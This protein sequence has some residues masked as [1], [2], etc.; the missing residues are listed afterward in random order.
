[1]PSNYTRKTVKA[2]WSSE[3]ME[4]A[5]NAIHNG[6]STREVSRTFGIARS[7]LQDR[8]KHGNNASG[9]SMGRRPVFTKDEKLLTNQVIKLSKLFYGISPTEIKR[10][11]FDYAREN[12][13]NNPFS[14]DSQ[15]AGKAWLRGFLKRNPTISLRKPEATSINRITAFNNDEVSR[16]YENLTTVMDKYQFPPTKI[17]NADETG[18]TTV[19]KPVK[20]YAEKGQRRVGFITSAKRGKTTTIM[21]AISASGIYVPPLFIYARKRMNIQLKRTIAAQTM[22]G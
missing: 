14:Q 7:T 3:Q 16:F 13:I 11:A 5:L 2:A 10:C 17:F 1:M 18:I 6:K 8:L 21:C 12:G 4:A 15:S 19:Q 9:P 22:G 20:V